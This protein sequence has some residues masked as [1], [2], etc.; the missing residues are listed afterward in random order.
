MQLNQ[1]TDLAFRILIYLANQPRWLDGDTGSAE[2][3]ARPKIREIA[4]YYEVSYNHLMKVANLLASR[5]HVRAHRGKGGGLEL[6]R[7]PEAISLGEVARDV[8]CHWHLVDCFGEGSRCPIQ[9]GCRLA[10]ILG[11]ALEAFWAVLDRHSLADIARVAGA[12]VPITFHRP[13]APTRSRTR[14]N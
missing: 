6:A 5:G 8:E 13:D 9:N 3:H 12:Q 7:A 10:P 4:S 2:A 11:E 14:G 1:Q